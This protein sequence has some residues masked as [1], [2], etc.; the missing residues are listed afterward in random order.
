MANFC[1]FVVLPP[2]GEGY[3]PL[4]KH[5]RGWVVAPVPRGAALLMRP[6]NQRGTALLASSGN[7]SERS[8]IW[9]TR[10]STWEA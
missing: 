9:L 8:I 10:S 7:Q 3:T 1:T 5:T 2:L 4:E 6:G